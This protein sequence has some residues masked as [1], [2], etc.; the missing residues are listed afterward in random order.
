MHAPARKHPTEAFYPPRPTLPPNP[1][2]QP[3]F[4]PTF[5]FLNLPHSFAQ[6][7]SGWR[8]HSWMFTWGNAFLVLLSYCNLA[9]WF[10]GTSKRLFWASRLYFL[11]SEPSFWHQGITFSYSSSRFAT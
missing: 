8:W 1:K 4:D 11:V 7:S 6:W 5:R 2:R 9:I 10:A 3:P